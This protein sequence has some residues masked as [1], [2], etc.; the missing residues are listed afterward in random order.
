MGG[1]KAPLLQPC[2]RIFHQIG[3][4]AVLLQHPAH[5]LQYPGV[6]IPGTLTE[7][8]GDAA[9]DHFAVNKMPG[10]VDVQ[11]RPDVSG[12]GKLLPHRGRQHHRAQLLPVAADGVFLVFLEHAV[13]PEGV[14]HPLP[15]QSHNQP[16]LLGALDV[17]NVQ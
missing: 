10:V 16:A 4:A 1:S 11:H 17:V 14:D 12:N 9:L 3:I 6:Q 13:K 8:G 2:H 15:C 7:I 5:P